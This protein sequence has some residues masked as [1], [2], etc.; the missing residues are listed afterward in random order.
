MNINSLRRCRDGRW[1]IIFIIVIVSSRSY[2]TL[3]IPSYFFET[4]VFPGNDGWSDHLFYARGLIPP[5]LRQAAGQDLYIFEDRTVISALWL[6]R[7]V[8]WLSILTAVPRCLPYRIPGESFL[9]TIALLRTTN[10]STTFNAPFWFAIS[11]LAV[12]S[13]SLHT[14]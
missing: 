7:W 5:T 9:A 3:G 11:V 1:N 10:A 14:T 6:G 8:K 4:N 13:S 2:S 12:P